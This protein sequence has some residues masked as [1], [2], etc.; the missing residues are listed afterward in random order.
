MQIPYN[1]PSFDE[2]WPPNLLLSMWM[3]IMFYLCSQVATQIFLLFITFFFPKQGRHAPS[4]VG[5]SSRKQ[6]ENYRWHYRHIRKVNIHI[7]N[8]NILRLVDLSKL[9]LPCFFWQCDVQSRCEWSL[10]WLC[11]AWW[12]EWLELRNYVKSFTNAELNLTKCLPFMRHF[13]CVSSHLKRSGHAWGWKWR[14]DK[15]WI[16]HTL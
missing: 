1:D 12:L 6:L 11:K 10:C 16:Y 7:Q 8:Q 3:V 14:N 15:R 9:L 2:G 4:F 5:F 13:F